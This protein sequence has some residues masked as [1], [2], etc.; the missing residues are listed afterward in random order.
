MP[1]REHSC[2]VRPNLVR[3]ISIARYTVGADKDCVNFV[4]LEE[5]SY[6]SVNHHAGRSS[7]LL[8]LICG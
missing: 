4:V 7:Q 6:H 2:I 5:R 8:K 1:L 3:S